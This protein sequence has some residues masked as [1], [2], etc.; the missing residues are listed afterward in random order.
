MKCSNFHK[1]EVM[2]KINILQIYE[3]F[4]IPR[5]PKSIEKDKFR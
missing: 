1:F 2:T 4:F 5:Y 3:E